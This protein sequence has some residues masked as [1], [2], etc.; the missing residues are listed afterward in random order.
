MRLVGVVAGEDQAGYEWGWRYRKSLDLVRSWVRQWDPVTQDEPLGWH[1]RPT[2]LV[3]RKAP[4][5]AED[6]AYNRERCVHG[7]Y[8]EAGQCS[9]AEVCDWFPGVRSVVR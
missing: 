5:R 3:V 4:R 2:G 1:K 9:I 7:T 8:L 6:P